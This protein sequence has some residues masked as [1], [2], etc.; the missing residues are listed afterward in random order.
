MTDSPTPQYE[1]A[2]LLAT[3]PK[4]PAITITIQ[5]WATPLVGLL[6]LVLGLL[7]GYLG[8][9]L[10]DANNPVQA[11][12]VPTSATPVDTSGSTNNQSAP[13][14]VAQVPDPSADGQALMAEMVAQTRHFIGDPDAPV[15]II[16]LSDFN[17]PY[18]KRHN[19]TTTPQI[20]SE[21][22]AAGLV[23]IGFLHMAFLAPDSALAAQAAECAADQD[24]FWEMHEQLFAASGSGFTSDS[25]TQL[26]AGL[27]LDTDEFTECLDSGKYADVVQADLDFAR[28]VGAQSTPSFLINGRPLVGAQDYTVFAQYIEASLSD[29]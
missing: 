13:G 23:R 9:P 5:S 10:L 26:A 12:V 1:P 17:C 25:L 28:S 27:D 4:S 18:C 21:F 14:T 8:R 15:T 11:A 16:E 19:T 22:V 29:Q 7:G 6:M 24:K 2:D 20:Q 3:E